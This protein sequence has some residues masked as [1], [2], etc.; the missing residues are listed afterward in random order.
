[1]KD[2]LGH[3]ITYVLDQPGRAGTLATGVVVGYSADGMEVEIQNDAG[4][5]VKFPVGLLV[6]KQFHGVAQLPLEGVSGRTPDAAR[7]TRAVPEPT[8]EEAHEALRVNAPRASESTRRKM[9]NKTPL[10][11][12]AAAAGPD[13]FA[14]GDKGR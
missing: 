10:D 8:A 3:R 11:H 12:G 6:V 1:M 9:G 14:G 13:E 2:N 4:E 7:E 5:L